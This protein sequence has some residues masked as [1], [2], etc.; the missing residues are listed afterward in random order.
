MSGVI[1]YKDV[2]VTKGSALYEALENKK[3]LEAARIYW[4]CEVKFQ[5]HVQGTRWAKPV[6]QAEEELK[7]IQLQLETQRLYAEQ[8]KGKGSRTLL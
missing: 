1:F 4:E 7:R 8:I 6:G 2:I 3:S 5:K